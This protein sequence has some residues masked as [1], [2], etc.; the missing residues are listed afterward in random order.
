MY[1]MTDYDGVV[2][3]PELKKIK[4]LFCKHRNVIQ[5]EA[6]SK[7]GMCRISGCDI[8]EVCADCGKVLY[9]RHI[10]YGR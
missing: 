10:D 5:G 9:E 7:N 1:L 3:A 4:S 8:Y 2:E 6:C